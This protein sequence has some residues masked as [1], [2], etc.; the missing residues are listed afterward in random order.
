MKYL[1]ARFVA[2]LALALSTAFAVSLPANAREIDLADSHDASGSQKG[3]VLM[4]VSVSGDEPLNLV[5]VVFEQ[6]DDP[7]SRNVANIGKVMFS[8]NET[9][10]AGDGRWGR[11]V[12]LRLYA[13]E[14][15][16]PGTVAAMLTA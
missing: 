1:A 13:G 6:P 7:K 5:S 9:F 12:A 8:S 14:W 16:L 10:S 3:I 11:L 4:S 15:T 2:A